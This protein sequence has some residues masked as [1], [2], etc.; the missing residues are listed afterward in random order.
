MLRQSFKSLV[1][2][3]KVVEQK[4]MVAAANSL[5]MTPPAVSQQIQKLEDQIGLSLLN[6]N[7]RGLTLTD[8]GQAFYQKCRALI[9]AAD[10]ITSYSIHYTKLYE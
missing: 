1:I 6:R 3:T 9:E 4:S 7:T 8:A 2:F 5:K 10:V